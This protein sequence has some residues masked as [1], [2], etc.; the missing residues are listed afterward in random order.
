MPHILP[1]ILLA[2][3]LVQ[4]AAFAPASDTILEGGRT[5]SD[6]LTLWVQD[7]RYQDLGAQ[8]DTTMLLRKA[9]L[10]KHPQVGGP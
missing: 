4:N 9:R 5:R 3:P 7:M 2:I 1:W 8:G 10:D 6:I